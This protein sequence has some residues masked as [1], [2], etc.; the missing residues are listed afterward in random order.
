[1]T[2]EINVSFDIDFSAFRIDCESY[3]LYCP[4]RHM[5]KVKLYVTTFLR[6]TVS[7][8]LARPFF[9][10]EVKEIQFQVSGSDGIFIF[11]IK[12]TG[13]GRFVSIVSHYGLDDRGSIL[14]RGKEF[15]SSLCVQ[16]SFEAHP[17]SYR[18]FP[19]SK[20]WQGRDADHSPPSSG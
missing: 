13:W 7:Q 16:S 4:Q 19:G 3:G 17:A 9:R 12:N 5:H 2:S 11:L 20:A 14:G 8:L 18:I 15:S 10:V 1:M 6:W